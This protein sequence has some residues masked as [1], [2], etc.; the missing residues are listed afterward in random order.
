MR[1]CTRKVSLAASLA[2]PAREPA[3]RVGV[4]GGVF[5]RLGE[6]GEGGLMGS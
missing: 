4:I 6:Q 3:Y 5:D 2:H 1:S